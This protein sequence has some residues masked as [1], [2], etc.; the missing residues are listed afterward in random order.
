M[1]EAWHVDGD[2]RGEGTAKGRWR[3]RDVRETGDASGEVYRGRTGTAGP[4]TRE[5]A[6]EPII[7]HLEL[8][9]ALAARA[10]R[11]GREGRGGRWTVRGTIGPRDSGKEEVKRQGEKGRG[12][13]KRHRNHGK[14]DEREHRETKRQHTKR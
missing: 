8:I 12:T 2:G 11:G 1:K 13:H 7:E 3:A 4:C 5:T 6:Q 14:V 9:I 10:T